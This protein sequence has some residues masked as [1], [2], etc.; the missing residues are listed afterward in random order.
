MYHFFDEAMR[1]RAVHMA[2]MR[3]RKR[4]G[5]RERLR[6]AESITEY[7]F[8]IC[9]LLRSNEVCACVFLRSPIFPL[10]PTRM[11]LRKCRVNQERKVWRRFILWTTISFH[12]CV[13]L[14]GGSAVDGA[15]I[16]NRYKK[17][18]ENNAKTRIWNPVQESGISAGKMLQSTK[19]S[20]ISYIFWSKCSCPFTWQ[21]FFSR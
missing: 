2:C 16:Q 14:A 8:R 9:C 18:F 6:A 1:K 7:F 12:F 13:C 3:E 19:I 21:Y 17:R 15:R 10:L 20:H 4:Q 5:E 11:P